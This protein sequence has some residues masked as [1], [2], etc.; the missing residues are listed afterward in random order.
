M[1][2]YAGTTEQFRP[3]PSEVATWQNSLMALSMLVD[4]AELNGSSNGATAASVRQAK[5]EALWSRHGCGYWPGARLVHASAASQAAARIASAI[6]RLAA[7]RNVRAATPHAPSGPAP[8][9]V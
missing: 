1:K 7:Q 8:F 5:R 3:A 2:L 4:Q 6:V 9:Y